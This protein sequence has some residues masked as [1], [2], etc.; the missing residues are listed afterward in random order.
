M[1]G[2]SEKGFVAHSGLSAEAD[3]RPKDRVEAN[4]KWWSQKQLLLKGQA[5]YQ[6]TS[7]WVRDFLDIITRRK[8]SAVSYGFLAQQIES[9]FS[10]DKGTRSIV[11]SSA[12]SQDLSTEVLLLIAYSLNYELGKKVLV[13][14]G[15]FGF[16]D[17]S[18]R[19]GLKEADGLAE[20]LYQSGHDLTNLIQT[21]VDDGV[22]VLPR[23]QCSPSGSRQVKQ[24]TVSAMLADLDQF[25]YIL[26]QQSAITMDT[27][28]LPFAQEV[29]FVLLYLEERCTLVSEFESNQKT[30]H[31]YG[32]ENVGFI[33]SDSE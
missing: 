25:D 7:E 21:V 20:Y 15:A 9:R 6:T 16:S 32:I 4:E 12:D 33:M 8:P 22:F 5:I 31:E 3:S 17:L 14:D 2:R 27:R 10:E 24:E 23:G 26:I 28:F 29:D 30:L 19:L 1:N 13:I 11:V 18:Q